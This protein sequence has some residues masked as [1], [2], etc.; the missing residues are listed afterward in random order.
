MRAFVGRA[1]GSG[2]DERGAARCRRRN[3][4][5][6]GRP[7][8][9]LRR[10][11]RARDP[12][13]AAARAGGGLR[14]GA[15]RPRLRG[16]SSTAL[17]RDFVG[18]PT[19][20]TLAAR[21]S[22]RARLPRLPEARGPL[23]HRRAQDQQRARARRCSSKRMGKTRVVAET[24]AGQH[25]V[26]TATVCALLGLECVVYMG[27]EDMARQAPNVRR[28]R[29]LGAEVRGR[30]LRRA[31]AQGRDQRGDARL[32]HE[33]AHHPLPPGLG[34]RRASVPDDGARLPG[35]DRR[36]R[37]ARRSSR[38][39]GRLP[40]LLVACVGGGSN[41]IGLF[42]AFLEDDPVRDGRRG[43]G[44][45]LLAARRARRALPR[46]RGDGGVGV[47]HGTRTYLLQDEAGNVLPTHSVSAG[48]DYPGVGPEHAL[49]RDEGRVRYAVATDDEAL[50]AFHLL[51]ETRGS[52]PR[53]S[54]RTPWPGC[55][56]RRRARRQARPREPERPRRQ[57]PRDPRGGRG[58]GRRSV[59][60]LRSPATAPGSRSSATRERSAWAASCTSPGP[61]PPGDDGQIVGKGDA[62]A[63]TVQ[64]FKNV[65]RALDEAGASLAG[66][67]ADPHVRHRHLELGSGGPRARRGLPRHPARGHDGR[68]RGASSTPTCWWRSRWKPIVDG[69]RLPMTRIGG[70]LRRELRERRQARRSSPS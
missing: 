38:Q 55:C 12:D 19:P 47:L 28:M 45:P 22:E 57:G 48:L 8:R 32:G 61:P 1:G 62:Y 13:G 43:G 37:R 36:A 60:R 10:A 11:L 17:L 52:C 4:A 63:Q 15:A 46:R 30:R 54:R 56:G 18:R 3:V 24:G 7:L 21:L 23:P 59:S 53:S 14:R 69:G 40:D 64:I 49:L 51:A 50:A 6:C 31:H 58:C 5:G 26:A 33:R 27:T 2:R 65:E 9:A 29:L 68:G 34:A 39:D 41:A 70:A 44:R 66:R 20:L 25:G 42:F 67:G 35:G 16:A